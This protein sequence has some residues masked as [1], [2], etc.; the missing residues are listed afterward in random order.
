MLLRT[1]ASLRPAIT[2][3]ASA[4]V[5]AAA[6]ALLGTAPQPLVGLYIRFGPPLSLI[7]WTMADLRGTELAAIYDWGLLQCMVWPVLIPSCLERR[8]GRRAWPLVG[9]FLFLIL[10]LLLAAALRSSRC[11]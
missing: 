6:Y 8:Y 11:I 7:S 5:F 2:V 3:A 9:G 4:T 1:H 10:A